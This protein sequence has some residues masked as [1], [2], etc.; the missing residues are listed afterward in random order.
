MTHPTDLQNLLAK[1]RA[2]TPGPWR[3]MSDTDHP[4]ALYIAAANPSVVGPITEE[5]IEARTEIKSLVEKLMKAEADLASARE[6][7][8][9][10]PR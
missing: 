10:R 5:L 7:L 1:C 8:P 3:W 2:A 4:N 6:A 9:E